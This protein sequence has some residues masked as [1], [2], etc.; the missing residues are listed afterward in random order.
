MQTNTLRRLNRQA[1]SGHL[2][3]NSRNASLNYKIASKN[4]ETFIG[5]LE[6]IEPGKLSGLW[7]GMAVPADLHKAPN[8]FCRFR[9]FGSPALNY[10]GA[11]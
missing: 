2:S 7:N 11:A 3:D 5:T 6:E 1:P 9:I 4:A 10:R 8:G